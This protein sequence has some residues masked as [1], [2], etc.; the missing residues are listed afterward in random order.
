MQVKNISTRLVT[1][2]ATIVVPGETVEIAE[3]WRVSIKD[4]KNLE[5]IEEVAKR[6]RPAKVQDEEKAAE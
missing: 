5:I 3:E 2:G 4:S 6:G 1:I